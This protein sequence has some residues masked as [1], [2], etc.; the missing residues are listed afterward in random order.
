MGINRA[1]STA[2]YQVRKVSIWV[3]AGND[4]DQDYIPDH[5][6]C[7]DIDFNNDTSIFDPLDT[8]DDYLSVFGEGP[9]SHQCA[10]TS[11]STTSS[12]YDPCDIDT[13][14]GVFSEGLY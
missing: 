14:L 1:A 9:C 5:C 12:T 11:T 8:I 4:L 6:P 3:H 10:T 7:N 13:F 2:T